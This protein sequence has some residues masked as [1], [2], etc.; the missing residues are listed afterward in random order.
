VKVEER[1]GKRMGLYTINLV[2]IHAPTVQ[3]LRAIQKRHGFA[4]NFASSS[5]QACSKN[6]MGYTLLL[7]RNIKRRA[8]QSYT[9]SAITNFD[10][11]S[12]FDF[13]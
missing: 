4:C 13:V 5:G 8:S 12:K 10:H 3:K 7:R 9:K 6:L 2:S 11:A 1:K